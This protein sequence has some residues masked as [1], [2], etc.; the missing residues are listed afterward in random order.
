MLSSD[1]PGEVVA[2]AAAI[3][4]TLHNIIGADWHT[5]ASAIS[6]TP[7]AQTATSGD[8]RGDLKVCAGR[9]HDLTNREQDFVA[10]LIAATRWR[11]PSDKQQKWLADIAARLRRAA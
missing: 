2:A 3:T 7:P 8:W 11:E 6:P 5:L 4:R 10:N 1:Q 9:I